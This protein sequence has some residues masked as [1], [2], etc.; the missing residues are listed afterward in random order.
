MILLQ[1]N[2]KISS[3]RTWPCDVMSNTT[4]TDRNLQ[5]HVTSNNTAATDRILQNQPYGQ[6]WRKGRDSAEIKTWVVGG[7][8]PI[9][10]GLESP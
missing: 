2:R 4:A 3:P 6:T 8:Q 5:N 10:K 9:T 7:T 1:T